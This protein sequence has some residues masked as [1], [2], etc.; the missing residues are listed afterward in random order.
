MHVQKI[1]TYEVTDI[2]HVIREC[3][4]EITSRKM[5]MLLKMQNC[6]CI[7]LIASAKIKHKIESLFTFGSAAA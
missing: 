2:N 5:K 6:D 4:A 1:V 7:G 3:P